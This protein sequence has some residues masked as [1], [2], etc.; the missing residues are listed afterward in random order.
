MTILPTVNLNGTSADE[1]LAQI[2]AVLL[3]SNTLREALKSAT[4]HGR[5]YPN[6]DDIT[7]AREQHF[8]RL[9]ALENIEN[10]MVTM[11]LSIVRQQKGE[12][13]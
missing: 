2:A 5:D 13:M 3:A 4:P 8:A 11:G 1:L 12:G 6:P 10:D 7:A 9:Q